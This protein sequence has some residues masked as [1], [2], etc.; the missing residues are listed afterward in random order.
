[1]Y[2]A[3]PSIVNRNGIKQVIEI[4]LNN[5]EEDKLKK[6]ADI[7]KKHLNECIK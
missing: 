5:E 2:L 3:V 4:S 1:M 6:S 7:L